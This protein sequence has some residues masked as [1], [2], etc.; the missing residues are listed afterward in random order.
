[1]YFG[2][3]GHAAAPPSKGI[4][5]LRGRGLS[6]SVKYVITILRLWCRRAIFPLPT[7]R[8]AHGRAYLT[9]PAYL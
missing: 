3:S 4:P 9:A 2:G 6:D 7:P 8:I 5:I 1:M